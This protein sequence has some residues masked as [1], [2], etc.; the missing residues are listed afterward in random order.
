VSAEQV[1]ALRD[2]VT[3][4]GLYVGI[5][6]GGGVLGSQDQLGLVDAHREQWNLGAGLV[7]LSIKDRQSP[8]FAGIS[9]S[10][11]PDGAWREGVIDAMYTSHP[12]SGLNGGCLFSV[13]SG[14]TALA[15]VSRSLPV[16]DVP[17][18]AATESFEAPN[19]NAAIVGAQVGAGYAVLFGIE[20][21]Y[22][23]LFLRTGQL[24]ANL[25]LHSAVRR[26]TA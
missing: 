6:A 7:E 24:I 8:L 22:R 9:G 16:G 2:W 5:D 14:A 17:H 26:G 12:H 13:G 1:A 19:A 18:I 15:T 10:W 3:A 25:I 23:A 11:A 4:G 20:P 21:T